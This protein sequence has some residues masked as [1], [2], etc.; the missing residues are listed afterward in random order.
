V[1]A[2]GV[3]VTVVLVKQHFVLKSCL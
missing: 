1:H 2:T 3:V